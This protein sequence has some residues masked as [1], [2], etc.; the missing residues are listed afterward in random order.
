MGKLEHESYQLPPDLTLSKA[1]GYHGVKIS[2]DANT[3][4]PWVTIRGLTFHI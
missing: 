4:E 1:I 3:R 2:H